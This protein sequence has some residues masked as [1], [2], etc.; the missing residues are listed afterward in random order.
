VSELHQHPVIGA[1]LTSSLSNPTNLEPSNSFCLFNPFPNPSQ[2]NSE[3]HLEHG[4]QSST[5]S[6]SNPTSSTI[7]L[8]NL[9]NS[10]NL[11]NPLPQPNFPS[12]SNLR[13]QLYSDSIHAAIQNEHF[14]KMV[15]ATVNLWLER[16]EEGRINGLK[17]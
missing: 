10:S 4:Y 13:P 9:S 5:P 17:I 1:F 7:H 14:R 2:E 3:I 6:P 12:S 11:T 16:L 8:P 15:F